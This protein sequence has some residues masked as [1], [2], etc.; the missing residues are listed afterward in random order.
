[1]SV[2]QINNTTGAVLYLHHDQQGSTR[3][4]TGSGIEFLPAGI[5]Q[6]VNAFV[7]LPGVVAGLLR[8]SGESS[9]GC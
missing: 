2:E 3:L 1:L 9:D 8:P 6:G 7:G 5:R 4:I